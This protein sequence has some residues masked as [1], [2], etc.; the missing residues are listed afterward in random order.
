MAPL[1][2][3]SVHGTKNYTPFENRSS[4]NDNTDRYVPPTRKDNERLSESYESSDDS[5]MSSSDLTNN[6]SEGNSENSS[7]YVGENVS[8]SDDNISFE[9]DNNERSSLLPSGIKTYESGYPRRNHESSEVD[10]R[11]RKATKP[12]KRMQKQRDLNSR[13]HGRD[14]ARKFRSSRS[15]EKRHHDLGR[16]FSEYD[17]YCEEDTFMPS[18]D[19]LYSDRHSRA[20]F[21]EHERR[22]MEH[23]IRKQM[24]KEFEEQRCCN[25]LYRWCKS[26]PDVFSKRIEDIRCEAETF[27]GN[28]PLT[29]GAIGLAIVTLGVVWFKFAEVMLDSCKP[30]HFHSHQCTFPEFPGCFYCEPKVRGYRIAYGFHQACSAVAGAIAFLFILKICVARKVVIDE[31]NSPTTS[32]PAGLICMTIV[33]VAAGKGT[34]GKILVTSAAALHFCVA[35]WFILMAGS[36]NILPDPSWYP[37]TVGI[38]VSAVKTW[39]YYPMAGHF[40]MLVSQ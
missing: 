22:K 23:Q 8:H 10:R 24:M 7:V 28:L 15:R 31:M 5:C 30:V 12:P 27:I 18:P 21:Y 39:L 40:L 14:S 1:N 32:S 20:L 3:G 2:Y 26:A 37:N 38:G 11:G 34:L 19:Y 35:V 29:I 16:P 6:Q 9:D 25:R 17:P 13:R 36:F 33:C 4:L